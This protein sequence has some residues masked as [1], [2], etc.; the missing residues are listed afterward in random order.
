MS[1]QKKIAVVLSGC[2][3]NDGSEIHEAVLTMLAIDRQGAA[4]QC[5]APNVV[6]RDVIDHVTG[7]DG[8]PR[9]RVTVPLSA[10]Q[11]E[12]VMRESR[13][14]LVV[15]ASTRTQPD[16]LRSRLLHELGRVSPEKAKA[17]VTPSDS[18]RGRM[19]T[20]HPVELGPYRY[21]Q[22]ALHRCE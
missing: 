21:P 18:R 7:V 19:C 1:A 14:P 10:T 11:L 20:V 16:V 22:T 15:H 9:L 6:Q 13:P 5:F 12:R 3:V 2:G 4:Y 17:V 8:A